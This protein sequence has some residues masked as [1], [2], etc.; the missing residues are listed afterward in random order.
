LVQFSIMVTYSVPPI[1]GLI[2]MVRSQLVLGP[3]QAVT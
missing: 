2:F 3:I 1:T